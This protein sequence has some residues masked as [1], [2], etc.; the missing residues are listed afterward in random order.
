MRVNR[1]TAARNREKV[2]K[3][4]GRQFREH[5]YEGVGVAGLMKA[6]GLT[7]GG[8]YKQFKDKDALMVEATRVAMRDSLEGLKSERGGPAHPSLEA[9]AN[10]YLSPAHLLDRGEGCAFAALAAEAPRHGAELQAVFH[11]ELEAW[12]AGLTDPAK[13]QD[14][15]RCNVMS[16][17]AQMVGALVLARAVGNGPLSQEILACVRTRYADERRD[18]QSP[19]S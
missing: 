18:A 16:A 12:I 5:G 11:G 14:E 6:A 8:F 15:D 1:E 10:G 19:G 3:S 17:I 9:F 7:H 2:V 13:P 4:A